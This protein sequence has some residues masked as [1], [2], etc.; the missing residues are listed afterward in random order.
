MVASYGNCVVGFVHIGKSAFH[1]ASC[2]A[3]LH[4]GCVPLSKL[5]CLARYRLGPLHVSAALDKALLCIGNMAF[6][7]VQLGVNMSSYGSQDAH[8]L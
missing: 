4:K 2:S 1:Y 8:L 6:C 7:S 3:S 5:Q